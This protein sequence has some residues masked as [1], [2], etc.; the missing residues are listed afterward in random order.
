MTDET[1]PGADALPDEQ[2]IAENPEPEQPETT[3]EP[4]P[5]EKAKEAEH[6]DRVQKRI[7]K[8]VA[9]REAERQQRAQLQ[10]RLQEL[11]QQLKPAHSSKPDIGD[12]DSLDDYDKAL[13]EYAAQQARREIEAQQQQAKA[14]QQQAEMVARLEAAEAKAKAVY[15]DFDE[16]VTRGAQLV[17]ELHPMVTQAI[18]GEPDSGLIAYEL[19]G[20]PKAALA[21]AEMTPAQQLRE[22]V[23]VADR[24][25]TNPPT[26]K[27][28]VASS[29]AP[30]PITPVSANS[31]AT[32]DPSQMSTDEWIKWR[33]NQSK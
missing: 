19:I 24:L 23:R 12:F 3:P 29:K 16:K 31:P 25:S 5:D 8:L 7:D 13:S 26:R 2:P 27:P 1:L 9:E 33:R 10:Q 17:G 18:L 21:F 28:A 20:D 15:P 6:Q 22:I 4:E 14:Q 30:P 32:R 11:E